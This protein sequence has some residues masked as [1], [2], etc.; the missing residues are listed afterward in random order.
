VILFL[1]NLCNL[2][3]LLPQDKVIIF[4]MNSTEENNNIITVISDQ[5]SIFR[6]EA[7]STLTLDVELSGLQ[8]AEKNIT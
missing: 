2:H 7:C 4:T 5:I 3:T 6:G 1:S 8:D